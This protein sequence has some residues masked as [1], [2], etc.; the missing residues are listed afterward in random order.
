MLWFRVVDVSR[1]EDGDGEGTDAALRELDRL[2]HAL[3][4][5]DACQLYTRVETVLSHL[6]LA[7]RRRL[8]RRPP[9]SRPVLRPGVRAFHVGKPK[10]QFSGGLRSIRGILR[11]TG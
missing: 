11:Q 7:R 4:A 6:G 1:A 8:V 10:R 2:H 5:S 3:D 9:L